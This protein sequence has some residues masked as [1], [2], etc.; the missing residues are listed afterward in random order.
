LDLTLSYGNLVGTIPTEL[1]LLSKLTKLGLAQNSL[2]TDVPGDLFAKLTNLQ[3]LDLSF[4]YLTDFRIP[5]TNGYLSDLTLL[6]L[7]SANVAGTI[8]TELALLTKLTS[9]ILLSNKLTGTIPPLPGL[10]NLKVLMLS[11]NFLQG[12]IDCNLYALA[13]LVDCDRVMCECCED[14][15]S[16]IE[17]VTSLPCSSIPLLSSSEVG[18]ATPTTTAVPSVPGSTSVSP[19]TAVAPV[20]AAPTFSMALFD[21]LSNSSADGGAALST[22]G[23]SQQK[24]M[25]WLQN[26]FIPQN[27]TLT[28]NYHLL[29]TYA[30]ATL[31]YEWNLSV[32]PA[33]L[34]G[35]DACGWSG[36]GCNEELEVS[37]L[38]LTNSGASGSLPAEIYLMSSLTSVECLYCG[39]SG[40]IS[41]E[42]GQLTE[43]T[44][45]NMQYSTFASVA[46]ELG[47]LT[48]LT[49]LDF[50]AS[51]TLFTSIGRLTN[52]EY[53]SL[54]AFN[55]TIP[56][57]LGML[58]M[59]SSLNF[60][61][62]LFVG[63]IPSE[64]GQLTSLTNLNV[65][66]NL[67]GR[68]PSEIGLLTNL[69]EL[70]LSFNDHSGTLLSELS[71]LTSLSNLDVQGNQLTGTVTSE[72]GR[73]TSLANLLLN[74]NQFTGKLPSEIGLT[75]I[76]FVTLN[77]NQFTGELPM[78]FGQLN[79][80]GTF[81]RQ[82]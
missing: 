19:G 49:Y 76:V 8:P 57:E 40:N 51:G 17:G 14:T 66:T 70:N 61:T 46:T 65:R 24:A 55:G 3:Y 44:S 42:I 38:L 34:Q 74:S 29:Q 39:L 81:L 22:F 1:S 20:T 5:T 9:V 50:V 59:L 69:R 4:N 82:Q 68:I 12:V 64:I 52:L 26:E 15:Y 35:V 43:L 41:S 60:V 31:S 72:I 16:S 45:F 37:T 75:S 79:G 54:D 33:W 67:G 32:Y 11:F 71:Q 23:T 77:S 53:L 7:D 25:L 78:E 58:S 56:S 47:Q 18:I 13:P 73:L 2:V 6:D 28:F 63:S 80:Y 27:A 10:T 21:F 30:L 48:S 36:V 62:T